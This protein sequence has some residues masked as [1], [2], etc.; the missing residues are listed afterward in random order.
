MVEDILHQTIADLYFRLLVLCLRWV[1]GQADGR[2]S[3]A[4]LERL[5]VLRGE[6]SS[7]S[8]MG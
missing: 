3:L 7:T 8:S 2:G 1:A 6:L 5:V 4:R